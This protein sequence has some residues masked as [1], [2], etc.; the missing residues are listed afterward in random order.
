MQR[1][2]AATVAI[3][4]VLSRATRDVMVLNA[5]IRMRIK[6]DAVLLEEWQAAYKIE[7]SA[8]YLIGLGDAYAKL[9]DK[10]NAKKQYEAYMAD[11][12]ALDTDVAKG[13]LAALDQ[14]PA[15][16]DDLGLVD[17]RGQIPRGPAEH[18]HDAPVDVK[19]VLDLCE[20][21]PS[22]ELRLSLT[23]HALEDDDELVTRQAGNCVGRTHNVL[24]P[25][26][27]LL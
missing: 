13:K 16:G 14:A 15:G 4:D 18:V 12:L 1:V 19:G 25:H 17:G 6:H 27:K 21:F 8:E 24:E 2:T 22:H 9:G 23:V 11:P 10:A 7:P 5:I 26:R 3:R 20:D